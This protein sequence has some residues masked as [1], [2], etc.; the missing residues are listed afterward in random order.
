MKKKWLFMLVMMFTTAAFAK[1]LKTVVLTTKPQMHCES[2]EKKIKGNL[3]IEK[4]VKSIETNVAEQKVTVTYDADKTTAEKI[5]KGF[6]K[7]GY[8]VRQV[9]KDDKI[10]MDSNGSCPNM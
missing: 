9:K 3:R 2:C 4:G 8:T 7:F 6:E 5:S 1:N 10:K